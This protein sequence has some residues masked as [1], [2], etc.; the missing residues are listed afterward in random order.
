VLSD[1]IATMQPTIIKAREFEQELKKVAADIWRLPDDA[2]L[3]FVTANSVKSN[4]WVFLQIMREGERTATSP[5]EWV[6]RRNRVL[7]CVEGSAKRNGNGALAKSKLL[8]LVDDCSYSGSQL[9]MMG[10]NLAQ[11]LG[12]KQVL[13]CPVFATAQAISAL[14]DQ[15][16]A[17]VRHV[18]A[19]VP[20]VI[21]FNPDKAARKLF[22]SDLAICTRMSPRAPWVVTSLLQSLGV[23]AYG[24]KVSSGTHPSH[25]Y[26]PIKDKVWAGG[27]VMVIARA[28]SSAVVFDH[29]VADMVSIPTTWFVLGPTV[30]H[31]MQV[32]NPLLSSKSALQVMLLRWKEVLRCMDASPRNKHWEIDNE[33]GFIV[34]DADV[35]QAQQ[36]RKLE[37]IRLDQM[38]RFAPL[39]MPPNACGAHMQRALESG[40]WWDAKQ[41]EVMSWLMK[42]AD[43]EDE[44]TSDSHPTASCIDVAYKRKLRDR[45]RQLAQAGRCGVLA[46]AMGIVKSSSSP[47]QS[48]PS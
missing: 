30:R 41:A 10:S 12:I 2:Q 45:I 42:G 33:H 3:V 8:V 11:E 48:P 44:A 1:A 26:M 19:H 16:P 15:L 28:N 43:D 25:F 6:R 23:V 7:L 24:I 5:D 47:D 4:L 34:V 31:V 39:L 29:K 37:T 21:G 35:L 13:L 36:P 27:R 20:R 38:P 46:G 22:K 18:S 9:G 17:D 14:K 40:D 32:A